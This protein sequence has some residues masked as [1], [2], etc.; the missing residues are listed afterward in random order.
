MIYLVVNRLTH[1]LIFFLQ[2]NSVKKS[3]EEIT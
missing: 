3:T 1:P 2:Q